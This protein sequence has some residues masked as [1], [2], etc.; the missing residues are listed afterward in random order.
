MMVMIKPRLTRG[1]I[2]IRKN[3]GVYECTEELFQML[4]DLALSALPIGVHDIDKFYKEDA[5]PQW[6]S[7]PDGYRLL[8]DSSVSERSWPEDEGHENGNYFCDCCNCGRSFKG[9]K[10]RQLCRVC[11]AAP[12]RAGGK[13]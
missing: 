7:V 4:C 11:D 2:E 1:E 13:G 10:R 3:L 12:V 9:H 6:V 5:L 8:K